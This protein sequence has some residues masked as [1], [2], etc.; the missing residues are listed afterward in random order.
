M[1]HAATAWLVSLLACATSGC[2]KSDASRS[3]APIATDPTVGLA[4]GSA[5]ALKLDASPG[6]VAAALVAPA[7]P[8]TTTGAA[9]TDAALVFGDP[10]ELA[11]DEFAIAA[12]GKIAVAKLR[13]GAFVRI[14]LENRK[15]TPLETGG[16]ANHLVLSNDGSSY[17]T[18]NNSG[19]LFVNSTRVALPTM[20]VG[21]KQ[22]LSEAKTE[23]VVFMANDEIALLVSYAYYPML[24]E[25]RFVVLGAKHRVKSNVLVKRSSVEVGKCRLARN[26][27]G[28]IVFATVCIGSDFAIKVAD[29]KATVLAQAGDAP[30]GIAEQANGQVTRAAV[31][32]FGESAEF[33]VADDG[34]TWRTVVRERDPAGYPSG[35]RLTPLGT[36]YACEGMQRKGLFEIRENANRALV[37]QRQLP[38]YISAIAFTPDGNQAVLGLQNGQFALVDIS[39]VNH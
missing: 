9:A 25:Y 20:K 14:E 3:A 1:R 35:C 31:R 37:L 36:R 15:A 24:Y 28:T 21:P 33:W 4:H 29:G 22:E 11:V 32:N 8:A 17:A 13:T 12:N 19:E 27:N 16:G 6:G 2:A 18:I 30:A 5:V 34:G 10:G 7:A 38:D 23:A 39:A 26:R